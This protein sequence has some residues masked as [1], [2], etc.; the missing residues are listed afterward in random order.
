MAQLTIQNFKKQVSEETLKKAAQN[1]V[2]E[3]DEIEKGHFQAYVDQAEVTYDVFIHIND[4][5]AII[6]QGCDCMAEQRLCRHK[7]ALILFIM[8]GKSSVVPKKVSRKKLDPLDELVDAVDARDLK[9]WL[10]ALFAKNK[11]IGLAFTHHFSGDKITFN[12]GEVRQITQNAV[13]AV[14]KNKKNHLEGMHE[15]K[16]PCV[17]IQNKYLPARRFISV[18]TPTNARI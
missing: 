4:K 2:R 15:Y 16:L 12:P 11:D 18:L 5:G 9:V 3:C 8:Q 6:G 1:V 14:V 13:K 10:K 7:A 17:I